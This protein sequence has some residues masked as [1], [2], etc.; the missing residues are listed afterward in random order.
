[1]KNIILAFLAALFI[2]LGFNTV[3]TNGASKEIYDPE[4][5]KADIITN[6]GLDETW[7]TYMAVYGYV[8]GDYMYFYKSAASDRDVYRI[9]IKNYKLKKFKNN[10]FTPS[11]IDNYMFYNS[12]TTNKLYAVNLDT[13]KTMRLTK[14]GWSGYVR[15]YRDNIF[16]VDRTKDKNRL[17]VIKTDG[18]GKKRIA[19][20]VSYGTEEQDTIVTVYED[21]IYY[22]TY[23]ISKEGFV[24][25]TKVYRCNPDGTEKELMKKLKGISEVDL[26]IRD[27]DLMLAYTDHSQ[28]LTDK[29]YGH[30]TLYRYNGE[31]FLKLGFSG[32]YPQYYK[33]QEDGYWYSMDMIEYDSGKGF[34]IFKV[35]REGNRET[36]GIYPDIKGTYVGDFSL[37]N[38]YLL[39]YGDGGEGTDRVM[40][41]NKDGK[42][43]VDMEIAGYTDD[44]WMH[45]AIIRDNVYII[46]DNY[47]YETVNGELTLVDKCQKI[48]LKN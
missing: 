43:L 8:Y 26:L 38:G 45:A 3:E 35:D 32:K 15:K 12:F 25:G 36:F 40:V 4:S 21:K 41:F 19:S 2:S 7:T 13:G 34:K 23:Y 10:V 17:Y 47:K 9:G 37:K 31:K 11:F 24:K 1:M 30:N 14:D 46:H 48:N 16:F 44:C 20:S 29:P 28:M 42:I 27:L 39:S 6:C 5:I 18:S 22:L 33:R